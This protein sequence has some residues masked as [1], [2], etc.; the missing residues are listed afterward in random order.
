MR[1]AKIIFFKLIQEYKDKNHS[2]KVWYFITSD[3]F[4]NKNTMFEIA[5][6]RGNNL[7]HIK[8]L[9]SPS[10]NYKVSFSPTQKK[11][12]RHEKTCLRGS[13]QSEF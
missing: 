9:N 5:Q 3:D 11:G 1:V 10:L 8:D 13:R 2:V 12:P 7:P 4:Y 6:T